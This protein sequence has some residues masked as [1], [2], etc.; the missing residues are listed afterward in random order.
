MPDHPAL[1]RLKKYSPRL[2]RT[3]RKL[4]YAAV[5]H[6]NELLYERMF[7]HALN[8][9]G[10]ENRFYP[11]KSAASY[12]LLYLLLRSVTELPVK[13]VVELGVG[14]TTLLFD[15]LRK[16]FGL[17]ITSIDHDAEWRDRISSQVEHEVVLAPLREREVA[18]HRSEVYDFEGLALPGKID[19]LLVD[20]PVGRRHRSRWGALELI[21]SCLGED[22]IIVFDD[23]ERK[24]ELETIEQALS[25]LDARGVE[26]RVGVTESIHSQL[27]IAAGRFAE[28]AY[29]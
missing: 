26:Y 11:V 1:K 21:E 8:R 29:Y 28:A 2:V 7:S 24:G 27:L 9:F 6:S 3:S 18:G 19:L 5:V 4:A 12:S 25:L 17:E 13:K 14:Q 20:G 15:G 22:F 10:V 16:E 23:A